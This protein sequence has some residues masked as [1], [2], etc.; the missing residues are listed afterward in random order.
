[1]NLMQNISGEVAKQRSHFDSVVADSELRATPFDRSQFE[2][3]VT[4]LKEKLKSCDQVK[5][6]SSF[7]V[8]VV[9][10]GRMHATTTYTP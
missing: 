2:K 6:A 4:S 1:M 7:S 9:M 10:A 3:D 8:P 5:H